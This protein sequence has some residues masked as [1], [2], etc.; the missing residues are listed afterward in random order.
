[1]DRRYIAMIGKFNAE[2]QM[3]MDDTIETAIMRL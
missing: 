1:M 3:H 2:R